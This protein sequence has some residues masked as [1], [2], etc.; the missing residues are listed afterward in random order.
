MSAK[1]DQRFLRLAQHVADWSKDPSTQVGAV[2]TRGK[3]IV[4]LGFNGLPQDVDDR[5]D[6]LH[7]RSVKYE[8]VVHAEVNAILF[9]AAPLRYCTLY[10]W[11][12]PP[13]S[14]CAAVII[15]AG[16]NRIVSL[17]PEERWAESCKLGIEMFHE[18]NIEVDLW[19]VA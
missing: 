13:C 10:V 15:Q 5:T 16:I 4:S 1:W 3:R 2:I 6:R 12:M 9:A 18:A 7:D 11:P 17:N 19:E 8:M 14:R